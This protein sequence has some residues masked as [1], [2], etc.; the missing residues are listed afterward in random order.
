MALGWHQDALARIERVMGAMPRLAPE[1]L[2]RVIEEVR[3]GSLL[4]Q[5]IRYEAEPGDWVPALLL[6]PAI[7]SRFRRA[8]LCLHQTT[9]IGKE[10]PAG[11]GGLPNLHYA[12]ELA[13][14]GFVTLSPDYPNFGEY[15]F[16]PYSHGYASATMKGIVNHRQ[17]ARL[18]CSIAGVEGVAAI[19]HSLG[20]HNSLFAA[21]FESR[22]HAVVTSCGF[23]AFPKYYGGDLTGW[24]HKGYMP[25]IAALYSCDPKRMP[26]DFPDILRLISPRP[27]FV[28]APLHD[29]N[30]DPSGVDDCIRAVRSHYSDAARLVVEHPDC[31][32][33][34]PTEVRFRAYDFLERFL[35]PA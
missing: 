29:Q 32:H 9:R 28:N 12:R 7:P 33:D 1:P 31:G 25:R 22:I 2:Y 17:A 26:F 14:R 6:R 35:E 27:L 3:D 13:E 30:F 18:L 24:S 5:H 23:T 21:V 8:A 34:F 16:D 20:G 15:T 4:R 10:E 19:G 11:L